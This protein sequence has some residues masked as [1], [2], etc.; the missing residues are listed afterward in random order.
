MS[1]HPPDGAEGAAAGGTGAVHADLRV[2]DHTLARLT[3]HIARTTPGVARLQPSLTRGL[4]V[5]ARTVL[6]DRDR[7]RDAGAVTITHTDAG[8]IEVAVR[9]VTYLEPAPIETL[10]SLE[11]RLVDELTVSTG[12]HVTTALTIIAIG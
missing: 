11:Q 3:A 10:R 5:A 1:T 12:K 2:S 8:G 6:S 9:L 7:A 4:G